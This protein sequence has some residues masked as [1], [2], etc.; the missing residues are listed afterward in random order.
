MSPSY[1]RGGD[2]SIKM[3]GYVCWGSENVPILNDA[4]GKNKIPILKGSSAYF[5]PILWCNIKAKMYHSQR[6]FTI[7]HLLIIFV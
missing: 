4:L 6:S 2:S 7:H 1:V 5:I 3:P